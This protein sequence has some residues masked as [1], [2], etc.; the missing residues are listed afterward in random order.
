V[1]ELLNVTR[2]EE[3]RV[4]LSMKKTNLSLVAKE[5][6]SEF[7]QLADSRRVDLLI[8]V[9]NKD[10]LVLADPGKIKQVLVNLIDNAIK[11]NPE[12]ISVK[13]KVKNLQDSVEIAI[14]DNGVGIPEKL[15]G[16]IF[17]K[18][19]QVPGSY[20]KENKGSGL[21]LFI[22]KSLVE[23]HRG[24]IRLNSSPG[25]GCEFILNIPAVAS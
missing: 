8:A 10:K 25:K 11:Y 2:I 15:Q 18:F 22:V 24:S 21:G 4:K 16:R 6:V 12:A 17:D 7:Q 5:V 9:E 23:L 3:G 19:Q 14:A 20:I 1:E 13:I